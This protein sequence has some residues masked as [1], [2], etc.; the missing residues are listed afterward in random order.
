MKSIARQFRLAET[1]TS[2]SEW[3]RSLRDRR[4]RSY[5]ADTTRLLTSVSKRIKEAE[6]R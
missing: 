2:A 1:L 4:V 3:L 6:G 5:V